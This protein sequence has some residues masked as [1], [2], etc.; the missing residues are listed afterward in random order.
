M[1]K[2]IWPNIDIRDIASAAGVELDI[3]DETEIAE[4]QLKLH[5]GSILHLQTGESLDDYHVDH[6]LVA[7]AAAGADPEA[8]YTVEE[9]IETGAYGG[10]LG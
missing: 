6:T 9:E 5:D 8:L 4:L 2:R 7:G 10:D 1:A 3:N